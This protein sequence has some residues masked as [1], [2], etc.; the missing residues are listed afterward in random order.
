MIAAIGAAVVSAGAS[1]YVANVQIASTT[2]QANVEFHR[3]ESLKA[4]TDFYTAVRAATRTGA[5]IVKRLDENPVPETE[6]DQLTDRYN[7]EELPE[8]DRALTGIV[9]LASDTVRNHADATYLALKSTVEALNIRIGH[10]NNS[11]YRADQ[12]VEF[13]QT[14]PPRSAA[15]A[16]KLADMSDAMRRDLK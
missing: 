3:A 7:L 16:S 6:I 10:R 1:L 2:E 11:T 13:R 9:L 5:D 4:Y 12:A 15:L 8:I 14:F